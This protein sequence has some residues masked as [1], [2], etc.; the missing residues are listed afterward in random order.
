MESNGRWV[1]VG[2]EASPVAPSAGRIAATDHAY[3][4]GSGIYETL[5]TYHAHPFALD[6]HLKRL[7]AGTARVGWPTLPISEMAKVLRGL[8]ALRAPEESYLRLAVSPGHQF[9]GWNEPLQGPPAW[10]AYA[11]PLNPY[12]SAVYERGVRCI[13]ASRPRWNPGSFVP[14]VK[15]A[16]NPELQLAKREADAAGAYEALLLNPEGTAGG[17]RQQQRIPREGEDGRDPRPHFGNPRRRDPRRRP[18]PVRQSGPRSGGAARHA[19]GTPRGGG[20]LPRLH[21]ER[22]GSRGPDRE[23]FRRDRAHRG[24]SPTGS[25]ASSRS[26]PWRALESRLILV[27]RSPPVRGVNLSVE[28]NHAGARREHQHHPAFLHPH[29]GG[30][31]SRRCPPSTPWPGLSMTRSPPPPS[32]SSGSPL[33]RRPSPVR[34]RGSSWWRSPSLRDS[35]SSPTRLST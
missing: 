30:L 20:G 12:V 10:C 14:A 32:S 24:S 1:W 13:L 8:A 4:Y 17:G 29:G 35:T 7:A 31:L 19:R 3:L 23:A 34:G 2:G 16:G 22:G 6:E 5:R 15:F 27:G 26:T 28:G 18:P 21:A 25:W 11:G 9:P 33:T